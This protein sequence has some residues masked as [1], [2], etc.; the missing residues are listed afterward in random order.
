MRFNMNKVILSIICYSIGILAI[1]AQ[2]QSKSLLIYNDSIEL[3]G[4]LTYT[5]TSK[6]L[7]IW[8]HGSGD[9]DKD[10]NQKSA[11]V[12]ANYIRQLRDSLN[13]RNIAFY[14]YDKRT[15]NPKNT[16]YHSGIVL[17]DFVS[18]VKKTVSHL[19]E[20]KQFESITLI[21]HSQGS[22]VAMLASDGI[23]KYVS[24]AGPSER[25]DTTIIKQIS[26]QSAELGKSAKAHFKE[27]RETGKI[28]E[29]NPFLIS[30]F[31]EQNL[32]FMQNWMKYDP[33]AEIKK[34]KIPTL[35]INGTKDLQVKVEDAK[36]LKNVKSDAQ[37]VIIKNMNHV[38]KV[39]EKDADNYPS[40][41]S[42]DFELA[43]QLINSIC[44]FVK[45]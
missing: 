19:K 44:E 16:T 14:S 32:A 26:A 40:Y 35:I 10:G 23:D 3:P 38:L 17:D 25:I 36:A 24:L 45:K 31:A 37:L 27:L 11:N 43:P 29:V 30:I 6:D 8:V 15:S 22:L 12:K 39:I 34:L 20:N 4:I 33:V 1:E 21:G 18:D 9:V 42:P 2:I 13:Q 41:F 5:D 28:R 7:V